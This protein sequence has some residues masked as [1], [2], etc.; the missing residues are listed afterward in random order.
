[1]MTIEEE[2]ERLVAFL[3][4]P[5][6]FNVDWGGLL[7]IRPIDECSPP[8]HWE[9]DWTETDDSIA[10]EYHKRFYTLQEAAQYF[11]EKRRYLVYG[12]DFEAELMKEET[13]E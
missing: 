13:N 8:Q 2:V 1:M 7:A 6:G 12:L 4:H 11:V 9:V 5:A 10:C 3:S